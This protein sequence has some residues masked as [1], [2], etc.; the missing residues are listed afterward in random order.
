[1][2]LHPH[3]NKT[4]VGDVMLNLIKLRLRLRL[5]DLNAPFKYELEVPKY[6]ISIIMIDRDTHNI[7]W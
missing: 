4:G 7:S 6:W 2:I 3:S 5:I 1:M